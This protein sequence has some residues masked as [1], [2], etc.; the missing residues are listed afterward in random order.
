MQALIKTQFGRCSESVRQHCLRT[1]SWIRKI[2]KELGR[3]ELLSIWQLEEMSPVDYH[4]IGKAETEDTLGHCTTGARFFR[5][6]Y[7]T[8]TTCFA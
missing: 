7:E 3:E 6:L 8:K 5:N 1:G 4:D 2:I